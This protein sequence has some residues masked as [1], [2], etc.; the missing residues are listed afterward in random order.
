MVARGYVEQ[1]SYFERLQAIRLGAEPGD[2]M[3]VM[4]VA[5]LESWL[6]PSTCPAR[7]RLP[8]PASGG[9]DLITSFPGGAYRRQ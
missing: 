1:A 3:F 8:F 5:G 6:A 9:A 7:P 4:R 2:L